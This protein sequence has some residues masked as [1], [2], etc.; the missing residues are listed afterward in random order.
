MSG[1]VSFDRWSDG[2]TEFR[3]YKVWPNILLHSMLP[4]S[5]HS[6]AACRMLFIGAHFGFHVGPVEGI[7]HAVA[8]LPEGSK[9]KIWNHNWFWLGWRGVG[10]VWASKPESRS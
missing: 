5:E 1:P 2:H 7:Y 10:L 8:E 6:V 4:R 9:W 3:T